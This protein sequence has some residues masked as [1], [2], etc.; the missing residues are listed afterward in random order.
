MNINKTAEACT[1]CGLCEACCPF[2]A[3]HMQPDSHGFLYP[4]VDTKACT[5]C[6]ICLQ[7]CPVE[8]LPEPSANTQLFAG[9]A[10]DSSLL[11]RSSSGAIF[12]VFA[13]EI[14]RRGGI[15][16]GAAFDVNFSVV[17][18]AASTIQELNALCSSK[19]VQSRVTKDCYKQIKAALEEGRWVYFSG[20]P[21]QIAAV[22]NY[23]G[24]DYEHLILQD[25]A[26]HSVPSPLVWQNYCT[27]LE[28]EHGAPLNSF[29]FRCKHTS[30]EKYS[31]SATFANGAHF[32][33]TATE[34][35]YQQ[36]FIK[37]LFSRLSCFSCPFKGI[38]RC[39][40]V[41]LADFWGV[42][43]ICPQI[44]N[45]RG[46]SLI[47]L[48]SE[49]AKALFDACKEKITYLPVTSENTFMFNSA[50]ISSSKKPTLFDEFWQEYRSASFVSLV[51]QCCSLTPAERRQKCW[52]NSII[53]RI[54]R[55][56]TTK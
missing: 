21:C 33:Q 53:S 9:Y 47:L 42:K 16:F 5:D 2:Q 54:I 51:E 10:R 23:L 36:G 27:E 20:T 28:T 37:G 56:I 40:D 45:E 41:T 7:K 1:G 52:N 44:Y 29:S 48:H 17:H 15:V 3:I 6:G 34:N 11:D 18:T 32:L 14:I 25:I 46:T 30:W 13:T 24:N 50:M 35:P 38:D 43:G 19:Y 4:V 22:K 49:K 12:P 39:S 8:M 26:C 55:W 31:I